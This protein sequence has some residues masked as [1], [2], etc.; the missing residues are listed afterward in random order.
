MS[1]RIDAMSHENIQAQMQPFIDCLPVALLI[2][3]ELGRIVMANAP[4]ERLFGY[5]AEEL[6]GSEVERLVPASARQAHPGLRSQYV[7]APTARA[8]GTGRELYAVH[9]DGQLIP[10]EIGLNPYQSDQGRFVLASVIDISER[11]QA[12]VELKVS[13][14]RFDVMVRAVQ[15]YAILRL[16]AH[17]HIESW[18]EGAARIQGYSSEE[19]IGQSFERFYTDEARAAGLPAELLRRATTDGVAEDEGWRV[20]KDGSRFWASVDIAALRD[21]SGVVV[22]FT[23]ITRDLSEHKRVEA[24]LQMLIDQLNEAQ[25]LGKM[26]SWQLDLVN[27]VLTWSDEIFRIFEIDAQRFGASYEA[28]VEAIHPDDRAAVNEAYL[29]SVQARQSYEIT[30]RLLM[31]DGRI[32]YVHER[33]VTRYSV[34]GEPLMSLGTVQD[35]TERV[36]AE[37]ALRELNQAL[38]QRVAER[39]QALTDA[40]AQLTQSLTELQDTQAKLVQ[41]EKMA[42]IGGLVAGVAHEINTPVGVSVTAASHLDLLVGRYQALYREGALKRSDFEAL[43]KDTR[44]AADMI[45]ANLQRAAELIASFKRV[46]VDQS[47]EEQRDFRVC[48]YIADIL[49][50]LKPRLKNSPHSIA[51]DCAEELVVRSYP[52]AFSQILT[53]LVMNSITHA[54]DGVPAGQMT[55]SVSQQGRDLLLR[56]RDNGCGVTDEAR[57]KLFDPFFTTKRGQGGSGLGLHIIYNLVTQTL[58]GLIECYS[59]PGQGI[60]F[61]IVV[62]DC[63]IETV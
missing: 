9:K 1:A 63:V 37:T 38:E 35:I 12:A 14:E 10:V 11:K 25:R 29:A 55:I 22:G 18:N 48:G 49:L 31:P 2:I 33:G 28:F 30:H 21:G 53:N 45:L 46:A 19:I 54:F 47:S 32:K 60:G 27:N 4:A 42:A 57:G 26:G 8:M 43:L 15:D 24:A 59:E 40:N 50:S 52:G 5:S 36:Q 13:E 7:Q 56:Y 51:V 23:K 16:D 34:Q 17:G 39:T 58:G 62:P 61:E 44:E 41:S 3:D 20:R 6:V